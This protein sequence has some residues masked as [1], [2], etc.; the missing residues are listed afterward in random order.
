[1]SV[2][3][4]VLLVP[5]FLREILFVGREIAHCRCVFGEFQLGGLLGRVHPL[6]WK[7]F[8]LRLPS[9]HLVLSMG[10]QAPRSVFAVPFLHEVFA[11]LELEH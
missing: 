6:S 11:Q 10:E 1:M 9:V 7:F 3:Q 8:F 2:L 5:E 4:A